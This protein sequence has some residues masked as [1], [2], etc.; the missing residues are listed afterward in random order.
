MYGFQEQRAALVAAG[1]AFTGHSDSE[2]LLHLYDKYGLNCFEHMRG[3]FGFSLFDSKR[4]MF[5]AGRD[6]FG[7]KPLFYAV[8][9]GRLV[10]G[11]EVKALFSMGVPAVWNPEVVTKGDADSVILIVLVSECTS[12][13][14]YALIL[15]L[16]F[17]IATSSYSNLICSP[18]TV[19]IIRRNEFHH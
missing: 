3:E 5:V 4:N 8:H 11:S 16:H 17:C 6:R 13:A 15:L 19:L 14:A 18:S 2:V 12:S 10:V 7:I 9:D 1:H